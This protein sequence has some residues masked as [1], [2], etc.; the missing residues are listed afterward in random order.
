MR[1]LWSFLSA[2]LAF[3][4]PLVVLHAPMRILGHLREHHLDGRAEDVALVHGQRRLGRLRALE[5]HEA[6]GEPLGVPQLQRH[7]LHGPVALEALPQLQRSGVRGQIAHPEPA[8]LQAR[9]E[10]NGGDMGSRW[11]MSLTFSTDSS[12]SFY[13]IFIYL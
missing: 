12:I 1:P 9:L 13:F 2:R 3:V 5:A 10:R 7:E 11:E 8:L 6:K 4:V